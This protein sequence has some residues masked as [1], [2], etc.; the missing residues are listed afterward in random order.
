MGHPGGIRICICPM[1]EGGIFSLLTTFGEN[2]NR[3]FQYVTLFG[4][5]ACVSCVRLSQLTLFCC[6]YLAGDITI[7]IL[8]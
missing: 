6:L 7:G 4:R 5:Y 1:T 2:S 8:Y 3:M